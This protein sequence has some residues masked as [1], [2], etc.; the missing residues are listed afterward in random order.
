LEDFQRLASIVGNA[1]LTGSII[2]MR[3]GRIYRG[4]KVIFIVFLQIKLFSI[5][6]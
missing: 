3:Y 2:I 1:S 5:R 4:D 6:R